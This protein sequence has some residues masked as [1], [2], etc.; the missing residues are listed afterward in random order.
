MKARVRDSKI[1]FAR[2]LACMGVV[3]LHIGHVVGRVDEPVF[4]KALRSCIFADPV[5]VFWMITG[6]F[7]FGVTN[8]EKK[9]KNTIVKIVIPTCFVYIAGYLMADYLYGKL[10]GRGVV[11]FFVNYL[12]PLL[13]AKHPTIGVV[14]HTWYVIAYILVM[15]CLPIV[16]IF[17]DWL[18][19]S[20]VREIVFLVVTFALLVGNDLTY[21]GL[22]HLGFDGIPVIIG[23]YIFIIWGHIVYKYRHIFYK[24]VFCIIMPILYIV[25]NVIRSCYYIYSQQSKGEEAAIHITWWTTSFSIIVAVCVIGFSLSLISDKDTRFN[26]FINYLS[27]FSFDIYLI[28]PFIN[29][30]LYRMGYFDDVTK[31]F[32]DNPVISVLAALIVTFV[33]VFVLSFVIA[34]I[35]KKGILCIRTVLKRIQ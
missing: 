7:L 2:L 10:E 5:P 26:R 21:N 18:D 14:A 8:Y 6:F 19:K 22:L 31:I 35:I 1:E 34:W 23:A 27:G 16:K 13:L 32:G 9:W 4:F 30:V 3:I 29:A 33:I 25:T 17:V 15:L 11:D 12:S 24:K 28:H 20:K